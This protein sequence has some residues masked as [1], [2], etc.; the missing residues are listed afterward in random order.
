MQENSEDDESPGFEDIEPE[1][2]SSG[3]DIDETGEQAVY[4]ALFGLPDSDVD[5]I[6]EDDDYTDT[7]AR[8]SRCSDQREGGINHRREFS[9]A[10]GQGMAP[11]PDP[12]NVEKASDAQE[13]LSIPPFPKFNELQVPDLSE[14]E[15]QRL[16]S[17]RETFRE[18]VEEQIQ[19]MKQDDPANPMIKLLE[20]QYSPPPQEDSKNEPMTP[21]P[22]LQ[23]GPEITFLKYGLNSSA[24]V[25]PSKP[26]TLRKESEPEREDTQPP[27]TDARQETSSSDAKLEGSSIADPSTS[28]DAAADI[29]FLK[30]EPYARSRKRRGPP[31]EPE[32]ERWDRR[33]LPEDILP[34]PID[35]RKDAPRPMPDITAHV[36]S[37][38]GVRHNRATRLYE[39]LVRKSLTGPYAVPPLIVERD[40][41]TR[42][43][44]GDFSRSPV[45]RGPSGPGDHRN[46][47]RRVGEEDEIDDM[48]D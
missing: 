24:Y 38:I 40:P 39:T 22:T 14:R 28:R 21:T 4:D 11:K 7:M 27:R 12:S 13:N 33:D 17:W 36:G 20:D 25:R 30:S 2:S 34:P 15:R 3:R 31:K 6:E 8:Y 37:T 46:S 23:D 41:A 10:A 1:P 26:R 18:G 9:L 16:Q 45:P 48:L 5:S 19:R 35:T 29:T 47:S 42:S 44:K 32:P 43:S